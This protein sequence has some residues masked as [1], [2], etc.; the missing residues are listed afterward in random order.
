MLHHV[1]KVP[2]A[3]A[4]YKGAIPPVYHQRYLNLY[5][6]AKEK[7]GSHKRA[8]DNAVCVSEMQSNAAS[9]LQSSKKPLGK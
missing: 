2:D 7:F 1:L 3:L 6:N 5:N 4:K 9:T 8:V